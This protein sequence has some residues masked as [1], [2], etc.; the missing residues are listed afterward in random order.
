MY[1]SL[2]WLLCTD[3]SCSMSWL[4]LSTESNGGRPADGSNLR[5]F[6]NL[7]QSLL[8]YRTV[9][10]LA[11]ASATKIRHTISSDFL[12]MIHCDIHIDHPF[13]IHPVL[14]SPHPYLSQA[15]ATAI[16][17]SCIVTGGNYTRSAI[18]YKLSLITLWEE[19]LKTS[20][21]RCLRQ[22]SFRLHQLLVMDIPIPHMSR[23]LPE[24]PIETS[25]DGAQKPRRLRPELNDGIK[26]LKLACD[27]S[28]SVHNMFKVPVPS[29][30]AATCPCRY[31]RVSMCASLCPKEFPTCRGVEIKFKSVAMLTLVAL[32]VPLFARLP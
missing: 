28:V 1:V 5:S 16:C 24:T 22:I 13:L 4:H 20:L 2:I 30:A 9:D 18:V 8:P 23:S 6:P 27:F 21:A 31:V 7:R 29:R 14:V 10:Q 19:T 25:G 15:A 17:Q 26:L 3:Y 12:Y 11:Q 32:L